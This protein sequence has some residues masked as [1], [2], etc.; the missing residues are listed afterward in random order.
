MVS[1]YWIFSL[2]PSFFVFHCFL[3][4]SL[5]IQPCYKSSVG[6]LSKFSIVLYG[7]I[8]YRLHLLQQSCRLLCYQYANCNGRGFSPTQMGKTLGYI[9]VLLFTEASKHFYFSAVTTNLT[10]I[11]TVLI[12]LHIQISIKN[13]HKIL[14]SPTLQKTAENSASLVSNNI[15]KLWH[16]CAATNWETESSS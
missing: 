11:T 4:C 14:F 1:N 12:S 7:W 5:T 15:N 13:K 9:L 16:T 10:V 3:Q 8:S 2:V 6:Q